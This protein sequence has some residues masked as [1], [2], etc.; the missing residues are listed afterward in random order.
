MLEDTLTVARTTLQRG[1]KHAGMVRGPCTAWACRRASQ[2]GGLCDR[3][4]AAVTLDVARDLAGCG[5]DLDPAHIAVAVNLDL[6]VA[7]VTDTRVVPRKPRPVHRVAMEATLG[8]PLLHTENVH[9]I[10]G[11]K[12]DNSRANLELW[13]TCQPPGQRPTD[14]A[15]Y[16]RQLL[17]RYGTP[18]EQIMYE[19]A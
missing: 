12:W 6:Y 17:A 19:D 18:A 7:V 9:H 10:N 14:L 5:L 13:V 8:R 3:H 2:G 11:C 1:R 4:R 16:A 15:Q